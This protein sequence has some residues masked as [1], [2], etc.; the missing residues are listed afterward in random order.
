MQLVE[1]HL[2][3][4]DLA[5]GHWARRYPVLDRD[6]LRQAAYFGLRRAAERFDPERGVLFSTFAFHALRNAIQESIPDLLGVVRVPRAAM[7]PR[8]SVT[9][10][11]DDGAAP[12]P[13][14]DCTASDPAEVACHAEDRQRIR[15]ALGQLRHARDREVIARRFGLDGHAPENL[16]EIGEALGGISIERVRQLETRALTALRDLLAE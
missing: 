1:D 10:L 4:L 7:F 8:P 16:R 5:A 6:D 14:D 12:E 11:D 13:E 3:L 15:A 2:H 9:S